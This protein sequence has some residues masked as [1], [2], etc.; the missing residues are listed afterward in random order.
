MIHNYNYEALVETKRQIRNFGGTKIEKR[1]L[2]RFGCFLTAWRILMMCVDIR[3]QFYLIETWFIFMDK[4]IVVTKRQK[5]YFRGTKIEKCLLIRCGCLLTAQRDSHDMFRHQEVVLINREALKIKD[6]IHIMHNILCS[7]A[8]LRAIHA[9]QEALFISRIWGTN[10]FCS[11][12]QIV[13]I[14]FQGDH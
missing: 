14:T 10:A 6:F 1:L 7:C 4:A 8:Y 5:G 13:L 11:T 12:G 3:R 2:I 9:C